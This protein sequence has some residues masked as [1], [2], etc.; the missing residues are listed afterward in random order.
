MRNRFLAVC[1]DFR[2]FVDPGTGSA[3]GFLSEFGVHA[4]HPERD[5][6]AGQDN[7]E[8]VGRV[9]RQGL[10][11]LD[12]KPQALSFAPLTLE[13]FCYEVTHLWRKWLGRRSRRARLPWDRF[14]RV[15]NTNSLP[16]ARVV[17]S[18]YR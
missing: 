16:T 9:V 6:V 15:L 18:V 13:R 17:N 11:G 4:V 8:F 2:S 7:G 12:Q 5:A 14:S 1:P 10:N 3:K